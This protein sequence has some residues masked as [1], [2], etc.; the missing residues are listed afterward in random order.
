MTPTQYCAGCA[1]PLPNR[2]RFCPT[3]GRATVAGEASTILDESIGIEFSKELRHITVIFC[4][5]VGSTELSSLMDT[6]E[7]GELIQ[8]YQHRAAAIVRSFGGDVEGYSG[9]GI[10]FRFGWPQAHDDDATHAVTAALGI[11]EEMERLDRAHLDVRIGVHSGQAVVGLLGGAD[12]RATMA[13]GE[14][15]NVSARLQG[16]AEPGTVVASAA[17][18]A[19]VE[20]RFDVIPLGPLRLRGVSQ[21]IDAFRVL[22]PTGARSRIEVTAS[23]HDTLIGR[24]DE[25]G[26]LRHRWDDVRGGRGAA[27][28]ITGEP[29]V[30]KSR[31][32]LEVRDLVGSDP[33]RWVE[34]SCASYTR[35]SVLRPVVDM[36]EDTL[37]LRSESDPA[38]RLERV[39]SGLA[40]AGVSIPDGAELVASL[41]GIPSP[42]VMTISSE[43]R[44]ERTV[45][46]GVEWLIGLS[47][48]RPLILLIEDLHWC[49]PTTLDALGRLIDRISEAPIFL[50]L[51]ARTEFGEPWNR[52][53]LV[54]TLP[55]KPLEDSEVRELVATLGGGR[56]LPVPVVERIVTSAGGIPLYVEEV[57][58]SVLESGQLVGGEGTWDLASPRMDLE[59]PTTLQGSLLARLDRLGPAKSVVQ[60]AAVL[61]RTFTFDLLAT[62]SGMDAESLAL[63]LGRAVDSGLLLPAT[64]E[65]ESGYI[66]KHVL[67]Q[68]VAYESLLRRSRRA[69]HERV[70][71]VLDA[72]RSA[73]ATSALEV[74]ARHYEAA[75]LIRDAAVRYQEAATLAAEGSGHREAIA[76]LRRGISLARQ[77]DDGDEGR[78]LEIEM[79][80]ALGS[81]L[82]TR[83]YSDP[84][85]A[86]AYDR[87][88][89]LCELLGNDVRVGLALGGLSV[90]YINHGETALGA[91]LAE[92]ALAIGRERDDDTLEVLGAV[93][94]SL[95]RS[96]Q[97][98]AAESLE[99]AERALAAYRPERHR[100]LANRFGTDQGVAAH[101]FAGWSHLLLGHLDRGLQQL[102]DAVGLAEQLDQPFNRAFAL[103]FLATGHAERGE[104]AETLRFAEAARRLAEEQGFAFWA[105]IS[106]VWENAVR[107]ID[108]DDHNALGAV[109]EAGLVAGETGNRGGSTSV[110]ARVAEAAHAAGDRATT[111][112][113]LDMALS[114]SA[115]TGQPWWDSALMRQQ[116]QLHA[117]DAGSGTAADLVDPTHPWSR[118]ATWWRAAIGVADRHGFPVQGVRA[119]SDYARLLQKVG[120]SDEGYRLLRHWYDQCSEGLDTP[121]LSTVRAQLQELAAD[122][123]PD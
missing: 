19:L 51:T 15:L 5:L 113:V 60:V 103:A 112:A 87:A 77:L 63:L 42:S 95:A 10:L 38:A 71:R 65:N 59:I 18:I 23:R 27:V 52:A 6:E 57:G 24:V 69:I 72:Q 53:D 31:L 9:D 22:G 99:M 7:Y 89:E 4:D 25:I 37:S 66:F 11:V 83:S 33:H 91:D 56:S 108:L 118:A 40:L 104:T 78:D 81:S 85:L 100:F 26:V 115:E 35:M 105:G 96:F 43:L 58:R 114:L 121:V 123:R 1:D 50:L 111:Q 21:P 73:G 36:I 86:A 79:Q 39:R 90:F 47:R 80:L 34:S 74:V 3:C 41:L 98:R 92:R 94:L 64:P 45:E 12:R 68:E 20:G 32:A 48:K 120:R 88:R 97:G 44:L 54:T 122:L 13:V 62:V 17:T 101:V 28:L 49:D 29:G 70:A 116:A 67:V 102:V 2:A 55:L 106:G 14:T 109:I 16:E 84:D 8:T 30:G 117:D 76:F 93:Q 61:G 75:G 110:L 107:V 82:A 46:V 119:A